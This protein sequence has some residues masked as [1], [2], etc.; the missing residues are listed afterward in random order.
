MVQETNFSLTVY[1]AAQASVT[2]LDKNSTLDLA[3]M[4]GVVSSIPSGGRQLFAENF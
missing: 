3:V 2:Y 1:Q 4:I